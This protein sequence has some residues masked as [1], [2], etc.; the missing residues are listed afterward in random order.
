MIIYKKKSC[1]NYITNGWR[2]SPKESFLSE[3]LDGDGESIPVEGQKNWES[4][5]D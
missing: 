2:E 4:S 1:L 5:K 3:R